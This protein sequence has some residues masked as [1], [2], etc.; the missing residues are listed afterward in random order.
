MFNYGF[1]P[2]KKGGILLKKNIPVNLNGEMKV[3]K[4]VFNMLEN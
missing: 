2:L 4:I 3:V 1:F